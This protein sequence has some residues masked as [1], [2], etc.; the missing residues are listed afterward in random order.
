MDNFDNAPMRPP[1]APLEDTRVMELKDWLITLIV[2][3]IPCI[4][5]IMLF[6]WGFGA[7]NLNRRNFCRAQLLLCA[8]LLVLY[9]AILLIFGAAFTPLFQ[10]ILNEL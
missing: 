8:V 3:A 2:L 7:G 4:N 10:D 1:S 6:V 9:F 5:I